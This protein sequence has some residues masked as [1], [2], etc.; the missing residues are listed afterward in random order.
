MNR[1]AAPLRFLGL[2]VGGWI[3]LR[4]AFVYGPA[5]W[6]TQSISSPPRA[7]AARMAPAAPPAD[8]VHVDPRLAPP[9]ARPERGRARSALASAGPAQEEPAIAQARFDAPPIAAPG[10]PRAAVPSAAPPIPQAPLFPRPRR[11]VRWSASAWLLVRAGEGSAL[12]AGGTLGGSQAGAR[13]LYRLNRDAARP[14][15]VAGRLYLPLRRPA[16][17]EAAIGIDWQPAHAPLHLLAERRE[18]IAGQGRSAFSITFY[19]GRSFAL[20]R[21]FRID[22]YAQAGLVGARRRDG[23]V[24]GAARL[25]APAGPFEIGAGLW[26]AAQ[27]GVARIDAGPSASLRLPVRGANMRLYADWRFRL[28]GAATPASGPALTLAGDF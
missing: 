26:G 14:L 5:L 16:A 12:A 6:T 20:P 11:E 8:G 24:D 22:A 4:V 19:G 13:L 3:G 27:P 23:F 1:P 2:V 9:M 10:A 7:D 18:A 17:A 15:A 25:S 28:A 21:H